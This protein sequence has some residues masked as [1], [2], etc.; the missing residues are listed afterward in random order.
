MDIIKSSIINPV[1]VTVVV[2]L[3]LLFGFLG[4]SNLPY[5][6]TPNVVKPQ[7]SV[8]TTWGGATPYEIEREIIEEQEKA[9]KSIPGLV[10]YESSCKDN[11][12]SITLEFPIGTD[13]KSAMIDVTNKL[14]EVKS[15]PDNV[16]RPIIKASGESTSPV[17][18]TMLQTLP[19]NDTD[20]DSYKTFIDNEVKERLERIDGVA[21]LFYRGGTQK[22]LH[23]TL[24]HEKLAS[25]NL[26]VSKVMSVIKSENVDISAGSMDIA[27]RTYRIRTASE[28]GKIDELKD[29]VIKSDGL[30]RVTL[31]DI[32][33][34]SYGYEKKNSMIMFFGKPGIVIGY[35]PIP[36]TNVVELTNRIESV[37]NE[38]NDTI[39]KKKQLH[40]IWLKD[41]RKYI[42]G[43]ID[44]VQQNILVGGILAIIVLL[45]FLRSGTSTAVVAIAIPISIIATF[46][47]LQAMGRS[48]NTISL[49]GIS[50]AVGM[51]VDSAIV[52]LENIDRHRKMGKSI[53]ESAYD[54]TSEVW[55]ALIASAL[56][57]IAVFL[58]IIFLEDE[59]GQLFKDIAIAV[60]ASV[61]FSLFVSVAVIPMV[62]AQLAKFAPSKSLLK[63]SSGD[64]AIVQFGIK[65]NDK[66]M[67]LVHKSLKS[68]LSQAITIVILT[69]FSLFSVVA[70]FPK[71][72][73]LPQGN[74]NLIFNILI[75]P[76]GFSYEQKK[77]IGEALFKKYMPY[78]KGNVDGN[79][80]I[81]RLFFVAAGEFIMF[82]A[83]AK[84][85]DR[86]RELIPLFMPGINSFPG[87]FAISKQ[88]GVFEKGI[89]K[90]RTVDVDI[91]G[92]DLNKIVRASGA[93][94]GALKGAIKDA[95]I[96]PVPSIELLYP[97]VNIV[98]NRD[99][100]KAVGMSSQELGLTVDVLMD[101]RKIAEFKEDGQK[102]I[103]MILKSSNEEL[104]SPEKIYHTLIS[105]PSSGLMPIS[106]LASI[107][108]GVGISEIRHY[109]GKK[110]ITLQV[111]PPKHLTIEET[112]EIIN[113]KIV[114]SIK[115]KGLLKDL[116]VSLSGTADKLSQTVN[117][118][119]WSLILALIITYLLMVALFSNFIYPLVIMFTV[120]LATAG[121]FIGLKLTNIFVA[122]QPMDILTMLGF[123][124]LI[125]IVVNNA[126]LI[127][128]QSLNYIRVHGLEYKE[129]IIEGTRSRLRPIFMSSLTS[130]FGMLP[131][132]LIPGPGA[133]FYR[134]LGSVITGG[135]ALS[136]LFTLFAIP[137]LLL[138]VIKLENLKGV[139]D[140]SKE[141]TTTDTK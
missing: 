105:T 85:E 119:K 42:T 78:T 121:G 100:L 44:L 73:Y 82:G 70:L 4:L 109:N 67:S 104:D 89:G 30:R 9:L 88:S 27:R 141:D 15:Y 49:A 8:S 59:A 31:A 87:V 111:S 117:S 16:D 74:K 123:I 131:L 20:I 122:P 80:Q 33:D 19:N 62:W 54:G 94:F 103:D 12:G 18:W 14:N 125:G 95:R 56:T 37:V 11:R 55:G 60:T 90:G 69:T 13:I 35:K 57:T 110:T 63:E 102:K 32:A 79:P 6:L 132:V 75:P 24:D 22:E 118:M 38:L 40:I 64:S 107:Q 108:R 71:M 61:S 45:L 1:K 120:P 130:V 140:E 53:F 2:L 139:N 101:G 21:E 7:I 41:D 113:T 77:E 129:A 135:L 106:S 3:I 137:A 126:I 134:G 128:H 138:F 34:I 43:S 116:S 26:T 136:T 93:M 17:V 36:G 72:E 114:P 23:I 81:N 86:A 48:L 46:I 92:E 98:P 51:L 47:V 84:E 124:I 58:P 83:T 112:I 28:F 66:I 91:S 65:V 50:F 97:E 127:V 115:Q 99:S 133:E 68:K 10:S 39:L 25:Y 76:P 52:V 96:R 29:V 5:Q